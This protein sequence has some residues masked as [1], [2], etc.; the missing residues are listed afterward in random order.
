MIFYGLEINYI[1]FHKDNKYK[2][3]PNYAANQI[4]NAK[5]KHERNQGNYRKLI[6]ILYSAIYFHR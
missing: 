3:L 2:N 5:T 1:G 4:V 6:F